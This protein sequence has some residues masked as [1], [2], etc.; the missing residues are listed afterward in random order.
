MQVHEEKPKDLKELTDEHVGKGSVKIAHLGNFWLTSYGV[1]SVHRRHHVALLHC[2]AFSLIT[3]VARAD[4]KVSQPSSP[5][6]ASELTKSASL[7]GH[8]HHEL[9]SQS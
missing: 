5:S 2:L 9:L 3:T 4:W 6:P 8:D 7:V 1:I